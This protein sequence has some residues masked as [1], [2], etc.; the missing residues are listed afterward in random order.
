LAP[1]LVLIAIG[2]VTEAAGDL[3]PSVK[4][5]EEVVWTVLAALAVL[6]V[7]V[8]WATS[9]PARGQL[10]RGPDARAAELEGRP[11]PVVVG[12][13]P[14]RAASFQD[15]PAA[16]AGLVRAGA[17]GRAA[18]VAEQQSTVVSGLGGVGKTQLAAAY[19]RHLLQDGSVDVV[20]W[21]PAATRAGIITSYAQ[22]A[23]VVGLDS[24]HDPDGAAGRFLGWLATT[25]RSWLIVL[26][27]L[28]TAGDLD[29]FW[30][31]D[32]HPRG[33]TVV[34]TRRRDATLLAGRELVDLEV[35]TSAQ[36]Q[37]YLAERLPTTLADDTEGV[38]ADVGCLPL[39]L[40]HAAAFMIDRD[41]PCSAYRT[42]FAGERRRLA[43]VFPDPDTVF[44]GT[45]RTVATTWSL[46]IE[47]ANQLAPIGVAGA[48]LE[49]ASM[50]DPNGIPT[51]MFTTSAALDHLTQR[52]STA[53]GDSTSELTD[54]TV[55]DALAHLARFNLATVTDS[56]VRV[57][58]LVQH[59]VRD[60]LSPTDA[61]TT[62]RAAADA[63]LQLWPDIEL[64]PVPH[65]A[66]ARQ[67]SRG[68]RPAR[69]GRTVD[70]RPRWT[71]TAVPGRAQPR[72]AGQLTSAIVA[73]TL[74]HHQAGQ[75]LGPDHPHTL[76]AHSDLIN[77]RGDAGDAAGAA[78]EF[79]QLLPHHE[80]V[81]GPDHPDTLGTR[82]NLA[83]WR[84]QAGDVAGAAA[85]YEQLLP[86]LERVLGPD[87]PGTHATRAN[88]ANWQGRAGDPAGAAAALEELLPHRERLLG[89]DHPNTLGTRFNLASW[90]GKAGD[91]AG[92]AAAFEELLPRLERVLGP[93]HPET[94]NTRAGLASWQGHAGD[95]AGAAAA[96]EELL[97]DRERVLGPDHPDTLITRHDLAYWRAEAGDPAG[98]AAAYEELL[99]DMD[100][101]LGPD[102][103]DTLTTRHDLAYWRGLAGDPAG[104]AITDQRGADHNPKRWGFGSSRG[105]PATGGRTPA[106]PCL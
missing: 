80:R 55:R 102:H 15:R 32:H 25:E 96:L 99:T 66:A 10:D 12:S 82:F 41:L 63:V 83:H 54:E 65:R 60:T 43:E 45:A 40:S 67:R 73:V 16:L 84:G 92:A 57:H 95:P 89:P 36:A 72:E 4:G 22:S 26:D 85:A 6:A 103:P 77:L 46:S 9:G 100:R 52:T 78:A 91:P 38:A 69:R 30:P 18:V 49:L 20:V 17:V 11:R 13:I 70:H 94:L 81:L 71:P 29:G 97:P 56:V 42:R 37:A 64:D 53:P 58:A 44:D 61:A 87:N 7:V 33:H 34:T 62:I 106:D 75:Y 98:A 21:V 101:V 5:R 86:R 2:L 47:Q 19:A 104:A 3:L 79:E 28:T 48:V 88:L 39:A 27:D 59:A 90:R 14:P 93:D 35:F 8:E 24:G 68:G 51:D 31:P 23:G 1:V 50:L 105:R 74:L 76:V